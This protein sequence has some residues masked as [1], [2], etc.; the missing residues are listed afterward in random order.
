MTRLTALAFTLA[1]FAVFLLAVAG[2]GKGK[3]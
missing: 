1:L 2:C 3:Y